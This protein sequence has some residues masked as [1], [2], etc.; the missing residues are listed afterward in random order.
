MK[1]KSATRHVITGFDE[2]PDIKDYVD[3][4]VPE[5][6]IKNEE[7]GEVEPA[8]CLMRHIS[9]GERRRFLANGELGIVMTMTQ[10][11]RDRE[12]ERWR[13]WFDSGKRECELLKM[14]YVKEDGS[15]LFSNEE[16]KRL[17]EQRDLRPVFRLIAHSET[18]NLLTPDSITD[19]RKNV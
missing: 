6:G 16:V 2:I 11:E 9:Q 15:P 13:D 12:L 10:D 7:S 3:V 8:I 14:S 4:E 17:M 1:N 18:D 5:W 19:F